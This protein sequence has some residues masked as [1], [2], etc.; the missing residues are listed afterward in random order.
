MAS[1]SRAADNLVAVFNFQATCV[2]F[3]LALSPRFTPLPSRQRQ[4]SHAPSIAPL[5]P[6]RP[7]RL[8]LPFEAAHGQACVGEF[9]KDGAL[10]GG[11]ERSHSIP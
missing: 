5:L 7:N 10:H 2:F 3:L 9:H 6:C 8:V 4:L 11:L 1:S